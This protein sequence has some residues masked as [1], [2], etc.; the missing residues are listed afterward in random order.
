MNPSILEIS[1][2]RSLTLVNP[3]SGRSYVFA[4]WRIVGSAVA[5][6]LSAQLLDKAAQ[7]GQGLRITPHLASAGKGD[8]YTLRISR[9][10]DPNVPVHPRINHEAV[11]HIASFYAAQRWVVNDRI[12]FRQFFRL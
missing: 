10:T 2:Q 6:S 5:V 9:R 3:R 4:G 8:C 7:L 1:Q 11:Y 12:R